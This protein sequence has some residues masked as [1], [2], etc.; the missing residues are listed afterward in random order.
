MNK[1]LTSLA[2]SAI[3]AGP[4]AADC[5][6]SDING[7]WKAYPTAGIQGYWHC[8]MLVHNNGELR[9]GTTCVDS[10]G[11]HSQIVGGRLAVAQTCRVSGSLSTNLGPFFVDHAFMSP[12]KNTITG[13]GKD[14]AGLPVFVQIVRRPDWVGPPGLVR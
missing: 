2:F 7:S 8:G 14:T 5:V 13:V 3:L 11:V 9:S 10:N 6:P 4:A 1:L 12:D